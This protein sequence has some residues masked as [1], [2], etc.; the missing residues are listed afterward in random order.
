MDD[1]ASKA[2]VEIEL[3]HASE[4]NFW[5]GIQMDM[6]DGG[7]FVATHLPLEVGTRVRV[8]MILPGEEEAVI[9]KGHVTWTR[10]HHDNSDAPPGVGVFFVDIED[11]A[12]AKVRKFTETVRDPIFFAA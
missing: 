3:D 11:A 1:K 9:V 12:I 7:V 2:A 5:S 10:A 6:S 8:A 4:H